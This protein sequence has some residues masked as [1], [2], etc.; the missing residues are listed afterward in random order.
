MLTNFLVNLV[1]LL[2][3]LLTEVSNNELSFFN[4]LLKFITG[5][6]SGRGT[7]SLEDPADNFRFGSTSIIFLLL[8][9]SEEE[10]R[11][12]PFDAELLS[13]FLV[14]SGVYLSDEVWRSVFSELLGGFS[15]FWSKSLAMATI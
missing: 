8:S 1:I 5:D 3:V 14:F 9:F 11:R 10:K 12:E 4:F 7:N 6:F 15:V 2:D 13:K